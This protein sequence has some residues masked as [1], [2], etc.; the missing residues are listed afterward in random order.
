MSELLI[1]TGGWAYF[2]VPGLKTLEAYS[3]AFSFVEV[4]S[5]FYEI[6][7]LETVKSWRKRVLPD[8]EFSVKCHRDVTHRHIL[9]PNE[10]SLRTF[11]TMIEICNALRSKFLVLETPPKMDF[12]LEKMKSIEAFFNSVELKGTKLIWEVRRR[13]DEP[14]PRGLVELM[15]SHNIVQVVDLSRDVLATE[16]DILYS[17]VFGKGQHN[18]YQFT[19]EE[20]ESIDKKISKSSSETSI[21]SFHNVKMYKDAARFKIFKETGR[22]PTVTG[23]TGQQSL[24][25]VLL[26]DTVFPATKQELV[27]KQGWKVIDLTEKSRVH[28]S[29]V[30]EKLPDKRF[31]GIDEVLANLPSELLH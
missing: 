24:K 13:K 5:T 15:S 31:N 3:R 9:E 2:K 8:F 1:G 10:E 20:L 21:I 11:D 14:L 28:A 23:T 29:T 12:G 19:D 22:F 18:V 4:N 17:R 7:N 27:R 25:K 6:P 26:E 30:L 16:S